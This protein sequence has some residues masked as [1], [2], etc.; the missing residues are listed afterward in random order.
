MAKGINKIAGDPKKKGDYRM[1][2]TSVKHPLRAYTERLHPKGIP[3]SGSTYM[4]G[5]DFTQLQNSPYFCLL[6]Y[7]RA[8]KQKVWNEA[9]KRE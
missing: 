3:F 6:K 8:V 5:S 9:E 7:A 4:K 1:K 2:V